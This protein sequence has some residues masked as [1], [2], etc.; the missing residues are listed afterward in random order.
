[1]VFY[2]LRSLNIKRYYKNNMLKETYENY[3]QR[4]TGYHLSP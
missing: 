2:L 1:M 3:E 4:R